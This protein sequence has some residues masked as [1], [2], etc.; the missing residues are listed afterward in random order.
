MVSG[1]ETRSEKEAVVVKSY[2]STCDL[3]RSDISLANFDVLHCWA[4]LLND[5]AEFMPENVSLLHLDDHTCRQ[6]NT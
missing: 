6:V 2:L 3:E 5:T 4:N 1:D